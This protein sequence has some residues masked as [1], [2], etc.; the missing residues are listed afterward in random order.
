MTGPLDQD[1][2]YLEADAETQAEMEQEA[3]ETE[4]EALWAAGEEAAQAQYDREDDV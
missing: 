2:L 1:P 4:Q 3:Y